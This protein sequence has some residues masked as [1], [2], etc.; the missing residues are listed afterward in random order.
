MRVRW[1]VSVNV[2]RCVDGDWRK[3]GITNVNTASVNDR[4]NVIEN[5]SER[6]NENGSVT[7]NGETKNAPSLRGTDQT[8]HEPKN[9]LLHPRGN[10]QLQFIDCSSGP[11]DHLSGKPG[12][13]RD[14]SKNQGNVGAKI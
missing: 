8:G 6:E 5:G 4:K 1:N 12:N 3:S 14:F 2:M 9:D 7:V 13:V 10:C 11:S